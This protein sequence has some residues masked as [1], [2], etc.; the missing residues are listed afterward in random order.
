M[1]K[2]FLPRNKPVHNLYEID[3]EEDR[4][5]EQFASFGNYLV[6]PDIEG[7]Y[8]SKIPLSVRAILLLGR[9]VRP[10]KTKIT[11]TESHI[12]QTFELADLDP[13]QLW[14]VTYLPSNSYDTVFISHSYK[15]IRHMWG[16]FFYATKEVKFFCVY[17]GVKQTEKANLQRIYK[18]ILETYFAQE[19]NNN[20]SA[21]SLSGSYEESH[22]TPA[23]S[24][25]PATG[26]S[27]KASP[28]SPYLSWKVD[29]VF[30][31][32]SSDAMNQI[33]AL[34]LDYKT[35][36]HKP[37][38]AVLQSNKSPEE[39]AREGIPSL[40]NDFCVIKSPPNEDDFNYPALNWQFFAAKNLV[41]RFMENEDW[42]NERINYARLANLPLC[43]IETDA[44]KKHIIN[45][46]Y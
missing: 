20:N 30:S 23:A 42:L 6:S 37:V 2:K 19:N 11:L 43:N 38:I 25:D 28:S 24:I 15:I 29:A 26:L 7:I 39:L 44:R 35:K 9:I 41:M 36:T 4:F 34:L 22:E 16:I 21:P 5:I 45:F 31:E 32:K 12:S 27:Q 8:E 3:I 10:K 18:Q 46:F 1:V 40:M 17:E 33:E 14:E 13:R